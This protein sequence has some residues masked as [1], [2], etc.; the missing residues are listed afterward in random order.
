M[1]SNTKAIADKLRQVSRDISELAD[2]IDGNIPGDRGRTAR[3]IAV[4]REFDVKPS[5]GLSRE[6][7]SAVF[8]RHG[9]NPRSFGSW[10]QGGY[11]ARK[12]D[13]RW[14]TDP[15]RDWADRKT[16]EIVAQ[17]ASS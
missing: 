16:K 4:L 6:Q 11:L 5:Q 8:K 14:L 12:G 10:V 7:A 9:L 15:G 1:D 13:R 2:L 3:E 17:K